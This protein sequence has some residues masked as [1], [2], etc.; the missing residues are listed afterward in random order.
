MERSTARTE[1]P[2]VYK[3]F[4]IMAN[5]E[6]PDKMPDIAVPDLKKK[7]KEEKKK[8]GAAWGQGQGASAFQGATGGAGRAG[9]AAARAGAQAA[10]RSGASGF[11][12]IL[13]GS[14]GGGIQALLGRL[15]ATGVGKVVAAAMA[16]GALG[17]V[18]ALVAGLFGD[19][20]KGG[21]AA[22]NLG[23]IAST[24]KVDRNDGSSGL[25]MA[26]GG[27][28][29]EG[30]APA[31][32]KAE[33]G[34]E[35]PPAKDPGEGKDPGQGA[36]PGLGKDAGP[37]PSNAGGPRDLMANNLSGSKLSDGTGGNFGGKSIFSGGP[38]AGAG[39]KGKMGNFAGTKKAYKG[40]AVMKKI[41][42]SSDRRLN[43]GRRG[44]GKSRA[45]GQLRMTAPLSN[46]ATSATTAEEAASVATG[47]FEGSSPTGGTP[48]P[49]GP[50]GVPT[51]Q[52][53]QTQPQN[54]QT[55]QNPPYCTGDTCN[56]PHMK[57]PWEDRIKEAKNKLDWA[58]GL[59]LAASIAASA[60]VALAFATA[61]CGGM[62][63]FI[64]IALG[65][66]TVCALACAY[67]AWEIKNIGKEILMASEQ[68]LGGKKDPIAADIGQDLKDMASLLQEGALAA[69][70]SYGIGGYFLYD[71][72]NKKDDE[73]RTSAHQW[74]Q[75]R[76]VLYQLE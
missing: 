15:M 17:V 21:K 29:G 47:Q 16:V 26:G 28:Y 18:A 68:M 14:G 69:I 50:G 25:G 49:D 62:A 54:P 34:K 23:G 9:M 44:F 75:T 57:D 43:L 53:P 46:T 51:T 71:E 45:L 24:V 48:P 74:Q 39:F 32:A 4:N 60:A 36:D 70:P 22:P 33:D 59:L 73:F 8:A 37:G 27:L 3:R 56:V 76:E 7:E 2:E 10:A 11:S 52:N 64:P 5:E 35:A 66:A 1:S 65:I 58:K 67:L 63:I 6:L 20:A 31:A 40:K 38:K 55:P 42:G 30:E 19:G 72:I 41:T 12:S 13:S 61:C